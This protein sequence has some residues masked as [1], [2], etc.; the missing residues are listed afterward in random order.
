VVGDPAEAREDQEDH[1]E[2]EQLRHH[3]A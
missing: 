2:D 1:G 3:F